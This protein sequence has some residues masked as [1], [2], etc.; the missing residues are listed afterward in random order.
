VDE[1]GSTPL[2]RFLSL[3]R[4]LMLFHPRVGAR[5]YAMHLF[6]KADLQPGWNAV[7]SPPGAAVPVRYI[8]I[9]PEGG[10]NSEKKPDVPDSEIHHSY[11]SDLPPFDGSVAKQHL[12]LLAELLAAR[13]IPGYGS[14][15]LQETIAAIDA[16]AQHPL[17]GPTASVDERIDR[18]L[19][20]LKL[21]IESG[22][23]VARLI[24][25]VRDIIRDAFAFRLTITHA[26]NVLSIL[27]AHYLRLPSPLDQTSL[28]ERISACVDH[29]TDL[30]LAL[31]DDR[32]LL[33][34]TPFYEATYLA[35]LYGDAALLMCRQA[36]A[37]YPEGAEPRHR[38]ERRGLYIDEV[39]AHD[40][41]P[42]LMHPVDL[43]PFVPLE[44]VHAT[45]IGILDAGGIYAGAQGQGKGPVDVQPMWPKIEAYAA[46]AAEADIAATIDGANNPLT[47]GDLERL[48]MFRLTMQLGRNGK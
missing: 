22:E 18:D 9:L 12:L 20:R 42:C 6:G 48:Q 7:H 29:L 47:G 37:Q 40:L 1:A 39:M 25:P 32:Q 27:L 23:P 35:L 46:K 33:K 14:V 3:C 8:L 43:A 45:K 15:W 34:L 16:A 30:A 36:A 13:E 11:E 10:R 5:N 24:Q 21:A 28:P 44:Y 26:S 19:G 4:V 17:R 2:H 41:G 31:R 38:F